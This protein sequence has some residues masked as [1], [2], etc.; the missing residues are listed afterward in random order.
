DGE[1][2]DGGPRGEERLERTTG[3]L[4]CRHPARRA[5][6]DVPAKVPGE[7]GTEP[8]GGVAPGGGEDGPGRVE[9]RA[10]VRARRDAR[11]FAEDLGSEVPEVED[12]RDAGVQEGGEVVGD[13]G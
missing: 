4:W 11:P 13:V 5:G 12:R 10:Q 1:L 8:R 9:P 7:P 2:R 3:L 6:Q